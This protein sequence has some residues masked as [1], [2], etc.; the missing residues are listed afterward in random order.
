MSH[1]VTCQICKVR[2]DRDKIQAVRHNGRLYSHYTCEPDKEL[3]PLP[4]PKDKDLNDTTKIEIIK[5]Y[6]TV[7]SLDLLKK[8]ENVEEL[9][10]Y[11]LL[12]GK[13]VE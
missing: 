7:L 11:T 4:E 9:S 12:L 6:D 1:M 8:A 5:S 3:V 2:F 13:L 10:R